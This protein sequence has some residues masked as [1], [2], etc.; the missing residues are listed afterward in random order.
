MSG[1]VTIEHKVLEAPIIRVEACAPLKDGDLVATV[2]FLGRFDP[3]LPDAADHAD[4][5]VL[6]ALTRAGAA[7]DKAIALIST[8]ILEKAMKTAQKVRAI[9][10]GEV[11][12]WESG[13]GVKH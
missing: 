9:Q 12:G 11:E 2:H 3:T 10:S 6:D 13:E 7:V 1:K 8:A 4:P 5:E